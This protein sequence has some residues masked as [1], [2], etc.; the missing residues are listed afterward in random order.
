MLEVPQPEREDRYL[1]LEGSNRL[2]RWLLFYPATVMVSQ[3]V[4][5]S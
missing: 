3:L 4:P 2:S 5:P 1:N